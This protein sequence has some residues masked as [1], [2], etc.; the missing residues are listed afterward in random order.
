MLTS[1]L[2][3]YFALCSI[4]IP[5]DGSASKITVGRLHFRYSKKY[6]HPLSIFYFLFF[7]FYLLFLLFFVLYEFIY[8]FIHMLTS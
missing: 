1:L 2:V 6:C 5:D 8:L 3:Q 7:I 4:D